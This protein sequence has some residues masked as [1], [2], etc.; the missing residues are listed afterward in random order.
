[1]FSG[2]LN[3]FTVNKTFETNLEG[4]GYDKKYTKQQNS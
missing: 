4:R 2:K 3:P 1:M